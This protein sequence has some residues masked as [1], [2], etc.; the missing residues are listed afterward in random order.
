MMSVKGD[1]YTPLLVNQ[2]PLPSCFHA[3]KVPRLSGSC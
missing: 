2:W 3:E 1:P